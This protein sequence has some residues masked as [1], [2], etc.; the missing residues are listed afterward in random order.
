M[1]NDSDMTS[2]IIWKQMLKFFFPVAAGTL[3]Q[4]FYNAADALIV[5]KFVGTEALAAVGGSSATITGLMVSVF[6]SLACGS[7]VVVSQYYGAHKDSAL[8]RATGT[9]IAFCLILGVSLTIICEASRHFMLRL[10][11]TPS[12]IMES[13]ALYM[14]I[15]FLSI[16][17]MLLT[18]VESG[19]LRAVGDSR[20]PF[21]YMLIS[22]LANIALD[23]L[24]VAVIPMG[25]A[26]A[27]W[28][29]TAA[30]GLNAVLAG[31][32]LIKTDQ[33]YRIERKYL[34]IDKPIFKDMMRL[35]IP[36]ALQSGMYAISNMLVQASIN[37]FGTIAVAA[38]SLSGKLHGIYD[39]VE[40][41]MGAVITTFAG[42]NFGAGKYSRVK[43]GY[44]TTIRM[45]FPALIGAAGLTLLLARWLLPIF[46]DDPSVRETS[47]FILKW[48]VPFYPIGA[49]ISLNSGCMRGCGEVQKPTVI[50]ALCICVFRIVWI[51][52][53]CR[54][55]TTLTPVALIYGSSYS[56]TALTLTIYFRKWSRRVLSET[57]APPKELTE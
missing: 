38:W 57:G 14:G 31:I 45:F 53:V 35:G 56:L 24:L 52:T 15:Y 39:A 28:A 36:A 13:S 22:C 41:G 23:I 8:R 33:P 55:W 42:Q 49:L 34:R 30:Q 46:S 18:N 44:R 50:S 32:R 11:N 54:I 4:Q 2:G 20:T 37:S 43:E 16:T 3:I 51:F 7:S 25:V 48:L 1:R 17:F 21:I 27:A 10:L 9:G 47:F 5:G 29:T 6:V 40:I 19:I 12:D 26:G